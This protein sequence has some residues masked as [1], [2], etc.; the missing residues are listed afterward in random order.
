MT[1]PIRPEERGWNRRDAFRAV[2]ELAEKFD[3][4]TLGKSNSGAFE[5]ELHIFPI[6]GVCVTITILLGDWQ[7]NSD[8]VITNM[9]TLP[10]SECRKGFGTHVIQALI[11]WAKKH[12]FNEIRATQINNIDS[13]RFWQRNNFVL[14]VEQNPTGDLVLKLS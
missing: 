10:E 12:S 6:K 4:I 1:K 3:T 2:G 8:V 11:G 7:T 5:Y 13:Q 14:V 9:T